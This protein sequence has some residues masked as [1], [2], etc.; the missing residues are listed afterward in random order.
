[1]IR[2]VVM[3]KLL[4]DHDPS[5]VASLLAR[6]GALS[7]PGTL[8]YTVGEDLGLREGGWSFAIVADFVDEEAYRAYDA[9]GEHNA[10]RAELGP[11]VEQIAR[12]QFLV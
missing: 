11:H 2:N 8:A 6:F 4:E 7:T 9:D 10:L 3:V 12:V 5:V 1:V